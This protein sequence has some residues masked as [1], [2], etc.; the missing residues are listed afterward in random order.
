M[1]FTS[2]EFLV[3]FALVVAL[4]WPMQNQNLEKWFLLAASW[5]FYMSWNPPFVLLLLGITTSDYFIGKAIARSSKSSIKHL[6]MGASLVIDLGVLAFFKYANFLTEQWRGVLLM[7]GV[8]ADPVFWDVILPVGISFFVFQSLS[9]TFDIYRGK[10]APTNSWRDYSLFVAFF[11]Q[12]VA[13]PIVRAADFL[14]QLSSRTRPD[15][16]LFESGLA[17]FLLGAFKKAVLSDQL[18]PQVDLVFNSPGQFDQLSLILALLGFTAQIYLD[19][20]GYSDMAIGCARMMGYRFADNFAMPYKAFSITEFWRRWHISLSTWLRD[21]VY[22]SFGGGRH[23]TIRT[24]INLLATMLLGGLWHGASWN[25][26]LWGGVH[27]VA[28]CLHKG[29]CMLVRK[30]PSDPIHGIGAAVFGWSL[31]FLVV[32]LAWIPFRCVN[33][34]DSSDF[35]LGVVG[36]GTG[37]IRTIAPQLLAGIFIL[38]LGHVLFCKDRSWDTEIPFRPFWLRFATYTFLG[39]AIVLFAVTQA[40]PFIYFQF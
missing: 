22:I 35:L 30:N 1:I 34:S 3:F 26:V 6:L 20:S 28:L 7:V 31:T 17:L 9:Y 15:P 18:A 25:F 12:L 19:F 39:S 14:P 40:A 33:F 4:R 2:L 27:G 37:G 16:A 32:A 8:Q 13:G 10:M 29:W 36:L 11:P 5:L 23:G 21:Y 24:Y 38:A